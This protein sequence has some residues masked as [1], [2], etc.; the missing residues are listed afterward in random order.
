MFPKATMNRNRPNTALMPANK[1]VITA[2]VERQRISRELGMSKA[3]V[4]EV[5]RKEKLY[6][7]CYSQSPLS[8]PEYRHVRIQLCERLR[9]ENSRN[10]IFFYPKC[11]NEARFTSDGAL[12]ININPIWAR[13]NS[14]AVRL[15]AYQIA[16]GSVSG[17]LFSGTQ[18]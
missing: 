9:L 5:L 1:D 7:C 8:F 13:K 12:S 4:S 17:Q 3:T 18:S 16:S 11:L 14:H 2:A 6:P 15:L 10:E